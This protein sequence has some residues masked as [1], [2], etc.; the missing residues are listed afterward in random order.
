MMKPVQVAQRIHDQLV[1]GCDDAFCQGPACYTYKLKNDIV[2]TRRPTSPSALAEAFALAEQPDCHDYI[3]RGTTKTPKTWTPSAEEKTDSSS[4]EQTILARVLSKHPEISKRRSF[5][6]P[7]S[8]STTV[9]EGFE[10]NLPV[11]PQLEDPLE[12]ARR[13]YNQPLLEGE[14]SRRP[15]R[16]ILS[17]SPTSYQAAFFRSLC[18]LQMQKEASSAELLQNLVEKS[19][20]VANAYRMIREWNGLKSLDSFFFMEVSRDNLVPEAL[21]NLWRI[22]QRKLRLPFRVRIREHGE[23]PHTPTGA[24]DAGGVSQ[25]FFHLVVGEA[26][27]VDYAT[28]RPLDDRDMVWFNPWSLEPLYKLE[29]LGSLVALAIHNGF[30]LPINLP[31]LVYWRLQ[32]PSAAPEDAPIADGWPHHYD[33]FR[34][35]LEDTTGTVAEAYDL[36]F[37]FQLPSTGYGDDHAGPAVDMSDV[38]IHQPWTPQDAL[39]FSRTHPNREPSCPVTSDNSRAYISRWL[40]WLVNKSVA[41]QL[42]AFCKGVHAVLSPEMLSTIL[43]QTLK[44]LTEGEQ[45][46]DTRDLERHTEYKTYIQSSRFVRNFW[47]V[48]HAFDPDE[49]RALLMFVTGSSR[50]PASGAQGLGFVVAAGQWGDGERFEE[51]RVGG[52]EDRALCT[53]STCA[54]TLFLPP[55]SGVAIVERMLRIALR[56][57]VGFGLV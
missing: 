8:I 55:W 40:H 10:S 56:E 57:A 4:L 53:A 16:H 18:F 32:N 47:Q 1:Y 24:Q 41:P 25:E 38:S 5:K 35:L 33:V 54:R 3:C 22:D 17:K 7:L 37:T 13:W 28:F 19:G 29:M 31:L 27:S 6:S 43:P 42:D 30:V 34:E 12:A 49:K 39:K 23:D 9:S 44:K 26:F 11:L 20:Q 14:C 15:P 36:Q 51:G 50:L 2:P 48:V 45:S 46:I 52:P 21:N